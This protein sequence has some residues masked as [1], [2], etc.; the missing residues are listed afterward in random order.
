MIFLA[1]DQK[2]ILTKDGHSIHV[3]QYGKKDG[4][5]I[6]VFHGGPGSGTNKSCLNW[7]NLNSQRVIL[8][9]QRGSGKSRPIGELKNNNITSL[10][11][12]IEMIRN[13][14][15][16]KRWMVVGGSWGATLALVYSSKYS[17]NVSSIV[18]RGSFLC[19]KREINWFFQELRAIIPTAWNTL[20]EGWDCSSKKNV[21]QTL[22]KKILF[23]SIVDAENTA[24]RWSYFENSAMLLTSKKKIQDHIFNENQ[25]L[26]EKVL[27]KYRIQAH[28]LS[29]KCFIKK[30]SIFK[31]TSKLKKI[32]M[33]LIHGKLDLICPPENA[34]IL[35]KMLPHADLRWVDRSGH[36]TGEKEIELAIKKAI[37]DLLKNNFF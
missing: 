7:F 37:E 35:K 14:L 2:T 30:N 10:I 9:D 16:I 3:E 17:N 25:H 6:V 4:P 22:S 26:E 8:F 1:F 36:S 31:M 15:N 13:K 33:V 24:L 32:P 28:Y 20:T 18:L 21:L 19:T 23:G 27:S 29:N 11:S 34:F 5:A 12:D